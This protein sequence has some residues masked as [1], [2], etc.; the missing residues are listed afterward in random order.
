M[1]TNNQSYTLFTNVRAE[2]DRDESTPVAERSQQNIGL[3]LPN[4]ISTNA[5]ANSISKPGD[6]MYSVEADEVAFFSRLFGWQPINA[7]ERIPSYADFY[8]NLEIAPSPY[9]QGVA[10]PL[11]IGRVANRAAFGALTVNTS[12]ANYPVIIN[13]SALTVD[14]MVNACLTL[15]SDQD[16]T[17]VALRY[18]LEGAIS[19]TTP[20]FE[21]VLVIAAQAWQIIGNSVIRMPPGSSLAL[22][23]VT[24]KNANILTTFANVTIQEL[25]SF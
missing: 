9:L 24:D 5:P 3:G 17:I 7:P 13:S 8:Q 19:P 14:A 6:I 18:A 20:A 23:I 12:V 1:P 4:F 22:Y 10:T 25:R 15:Q 16:L 21:G 11:A 2:K